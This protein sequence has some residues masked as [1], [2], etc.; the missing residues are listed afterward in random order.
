V[1]VERKE[2]RPGRTLEKPLLAGR[3]GP[4]IDPPEVFVA[5]EY[6]LRRG[7]GRPQGHQPVCLAHSRKAGQDGNI[8]R[9]RLTAGGSAAMRAN[10][11]DKRPVD[12]DRT[13]QGQPQDLR[14]ASAGLQRA[15]LEHVGGPDLDR[16]DDP[17][18]RNL[19]LNIESGRRDGR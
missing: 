12:G 6:D 17:G 5:A 16:I 2:V 19:G 7:V 18:P 13:T 1:L 8:A 10:N 11:D 4:R 15:I 14:P 3:Q 9:K